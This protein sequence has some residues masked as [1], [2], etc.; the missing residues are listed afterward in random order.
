MHL[1]STIK[2][3]LA[4]LCALP[5]TLS[6]HAQDATPKT[7]DFYPANIPVNYIR[8]WDALTPVT[9]PNQLMAKP[10]KEVMQS[11]AYVD[12][13]GRPLQTVIKQG[14]QLTNGQLADMVNMQVYDEYGREVR[15][16]L[17]FVSTGSSG[18]IKYDPFRQQTDFYKS[19]NQNSPLYN[20]NETFFYGKTEFEASPLN[21]VER[22]YAPGNSW[23]NQGKGIKVQYLMNTINDKVRIWNV[24]D[25]V[26][27]FGN[28]TTTVEYN[29]GELH[30]TITTDEENHQVIEFKDKAGLVI[31]K[32]VQ[33][34]T[35]TDNGTGSDHE[36]WLCTY[37]IYD[38]YNL[39]RAVIQPNGV[40][41]LR[42]HGWDRSE[43]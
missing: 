11:T 30:K 28:Y 19:S 34:N 10:R 15:R 43:E 38:D 27:G 40:E 32:K 12:G 33:V 3:S 21:R 14:A 13:L 31:L 16:Y 41:Y 26:N 20:Q 42:Q 7:Y 29:P 9:D 37:Y 25:V 2:L 17:P 23:V 22:T 8:T 35:V 4:M 5:A 24:N 6:L 1:N 39:L 36:N 18:V